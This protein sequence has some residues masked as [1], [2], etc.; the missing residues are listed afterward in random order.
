[1][2]DLAK[3]S[4]RKT[5]VSFKKLASAGPRTTIDIVAET[6]MMQVRILLLCALGEDLSEQEVDFWQSGRLEKR[7]LPEVLRETFHGLIN[8]MG[9]PH[10]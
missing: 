1:M 3:T 10:I 9:H 6:S 5:L 8:R 4:M 7:S 2:I